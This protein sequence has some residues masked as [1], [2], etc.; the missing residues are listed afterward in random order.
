MPPYHECTNESPCNIPDKISEPFHPLELPVV[1]FLVPFVGN[2]SLL[3]PKVRP[4]R[5]QIN[6]S[7]ILTSSQLPDVWTLVYIGIL[8][9]TRRTRTYEAS[10]DIPTRIFGQML[11]SDF[12]FS[13]EPSIARRSTEALY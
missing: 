2:Y 3:R 5:R 8:D 1:S 10:F 4:C 7:W 13:F 9:V 12:S 11:A 6:C